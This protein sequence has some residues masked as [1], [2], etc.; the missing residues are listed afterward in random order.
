MNN[1]IERKHWYKLGALIAVSFFFIAGWPAQA[2]G[3]VYCGVIDVYTDDDGKVTDVNLEVDNWKETAVYPLAVNK[4]M[5]SL[6]E[7]YQGEEVQIW[8][9]IVE[10]DG[11]E[12]IAVEKCLRVFFGLVQSTRDEED[13]LGSILLETDYET[14][15]L[16][17]DKKSK[18]LVGKLDGKMIRAVGSLKET[19]EGEMLVLDCYAE[20]VVVHG[21]FEVTVNDEGDATGIRF[22]GKCDGKAAAFDLP[23]N[24]NT[25][26]LAQQYEFDT[27]EISGTLEKDKG[28]TVLS[29][30]TCDLSTAVADEDDME[31]EERRDGGNEADD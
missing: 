21:R 17:I 18:E 30:L 10:K 25:A 1:K 13:N 14:Y 11:E 8:G 23:V 22:V 9:K 27:V 4:K 29:V 12:W 16:P 26:D 31:D 19:D 7:A 2:Q 20:F 15:F 28:Q 24:E 3:E 6:I 5:L